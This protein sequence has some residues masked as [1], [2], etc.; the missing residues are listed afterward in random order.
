MGMFSNYDD[1]ESIIK[2]EY[3]IK[4]KVEKGFFKSKKVYVEELTLKR[5]EIF[6]NGK[7]VSY[8]EIKKL[9]DTMIIKNVGTKTEQENG[10]YTWSIEKYTNDK[11]RGS[12]IERYN[13]NRDIYYRYSGYT[14]THELQ[15]NQQNL[16]I[17]DVQM[18]SKKYGESELS[19]ISEFEYD[20]NKRCTRF[21][22]NNYYDGRLQKI[23]EYLYEYDLRGNCVKKIGKENVL[24]KLM[25]DTDEKGERIMYISNKKYDSLNNVIFAEGINRGKSYESTYDYKYD[26]HNNCTECR[27]TVIENGKFD[28]EIVIRYHIKYK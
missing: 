9:N 17:R 3:I 28:C 21:V 13:R 1:I 4:E 12:E 23:N 11:Y 19:S 6:R 7:L 25:Y 15:Y 10:G 16:L 8:E 2:E 20:I 24:F 26:S 22:Y 5:K 27:I 14:Y 18:C